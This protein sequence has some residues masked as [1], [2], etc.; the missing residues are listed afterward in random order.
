MYFG[1]CPTGEIPG[2]GL[3]RCRVTLTTAQSTYE[4]LADGKNWLKVHVCEKARGRGKTRGQWPYRLRSTRA[5]TNLSSNFGGFRGLGGLQ[6]ASEVKFYLGFEIS[7]LDY[8]GIHVH[9]AS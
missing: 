4:K 7:N 8:H 3:E 1:L 6:M 5:M 9:I 2:H